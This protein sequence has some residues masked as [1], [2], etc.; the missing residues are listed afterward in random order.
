MDL[1]TKGFKFP[2]LFIEKGIEYEDGGGY[3]NILES[4]LDIER[5]IEKEICTHTVL[6]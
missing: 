2:R 6:T 3:Y 4:E 1:I 5:W